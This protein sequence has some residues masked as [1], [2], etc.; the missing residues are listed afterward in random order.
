MITLPKIVE[1]HCDAKIVRSVYDELGVKTTLTPAVHRMV[2]F[3]YADQLEFNQIGFLVD[4]DIHNNEMRNFKSET[5]RAKVT[6]PYSAVISL[7]EYQTEDDNKTRIGF[8]S[9]DN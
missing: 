7:V 3:Q 1:I 2:Y 4:V 8:F 5:I 9:E 6:I